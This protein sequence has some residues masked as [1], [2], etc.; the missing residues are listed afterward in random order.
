ME[1]SHRVRLRDRIREAAANWSDLRTA[2]KWGILASVA[3]GFLMVLTMVSASLVLMVLWH[4][5]QWIAMPVSLVR[6]LIPE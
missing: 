5:L 3:V 6:R 1:D 4:V 2:I